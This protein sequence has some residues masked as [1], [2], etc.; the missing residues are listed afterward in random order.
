MVCG[1]AIHQFNM[2]NS[3]AWNSLTTILKS[4]PIAA[5]PSLENLN[6]ATFLAAKG[7][8][9]SYLFWFCTFYAKLLSLECFLGEEWQSSTKNAI[10]FILALSLEKESTKVPKKVKRS[11]C[12]FIHAFLFCVPSY[13]LK[14][15]DFHI[16]IPFLERLTS[17]ASEAVGGRSTLVLK[18]SKSDIRKTQN[19]LETSNYLTSMASEA[20]RGRFLNK[21]FWHYWKVLNDFKG[22][23]NADVLW[24]LPLYFFF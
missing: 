2:F 6:S 1:C 15:L 18:T 4:Y 17:T 11:I 3:N 23:F 22:S 14:K 20:V 5:E 13:L 12:F 8:T 10:I 24:V 9:R 7:T 16:H 19:I 21:C